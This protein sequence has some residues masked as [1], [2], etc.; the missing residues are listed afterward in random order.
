M[1]KQKLKLYLSGGGD[2]T[3]SFALDKLFFTSIPENGKV[4]YIPIALRGH[5]L[6]L[7]AHMWFSGV[8]KKH[9]RD[10]IQ[11]VR[12]DDVDTITI[13]KISLYDAVYI[14]GGNT[15][16]LIKEVSEAGFDEVLKKYIT[17]GGVVYGGSA[18]AILLGTCIDTSDDENVVKW[19]NINGLDLIS[20]YSV[21]CHYTEVMEKRYSGWA[22]KHGPIICIPENAGMYTEGNS[23]VNCGNG[24]ITV[25]DTSGKKIEYSANECLMFE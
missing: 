25:F 16:S 15:W 2:E 24:M 7:N 1:K 4:L 10:D 18:G 13:K 23:L 20:P 17:E 5:K 9:G 19:N 8:V 22:N 11:V 3:Q 12:C 14:G 21:V 6:F